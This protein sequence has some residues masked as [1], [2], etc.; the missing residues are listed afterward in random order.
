M[1]H[2]LHPHLRS[3]VV[4]WTSCAVLALT[5]IASISVTA[6]KSSMQN[7]NLHDNP[8]LTESPLPYHYPLFDKIRNDHF[9]PAIEAGMREQLQEIEPIAS[10][11]EKPT[12]E[13]TVVALER[14]GRLLDRAEST[15]S[16][17]NACNTNPEMQKIEEEMAPKLSAHRDAIHLNGKLFA[18]IQYLYD[19]RDKLGLD[20]ESAYLL[21]RYYKDFVR[22]G[23][24]LSQ[25]DQEKLKKINSEL[26][27]LQTQFEQ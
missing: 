21:E 8:L 7:S 11:S 1:H 22:A 19:N 10:N 26:A 25:P 6:Q 15:F 9:A 3:T 12:F 23:A 16:N 24:K 27:T 2:C 14:T 20:P 13:N 4:P 17:L 18:R 5:Q